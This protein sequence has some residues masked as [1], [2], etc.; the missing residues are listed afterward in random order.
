[1][2]GKGVVVALM[3]GVRMESMGM[4]KGCCRKNCLSYWPTEKEKT[5]KHYWRK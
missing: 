5:A 4:G 1:V 2:N 3:K